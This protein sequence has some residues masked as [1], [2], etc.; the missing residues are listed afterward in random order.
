MCVGKCSRYVGL[1]LVLLSLLSI[2]LQLFLLYP[3]FD[4]SYLDE[5]NISSH[6]RK[7]AGIWA[8]GLLVGRH[9]CKSK[10]SI[11]FDLLF[12]ILLYTSD[13]YVFG[14]PVWSDICDKP[15]MIV[16][17]TFSFFFLLGLVG[18]LQV[19]L[20]FFQI[21]NSFIGI[22]GGRCDGYKWRADDGP[23]DK[24]KAPETGGKEDSL[25][26]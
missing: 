7:Y 2:A 20:S 11:S 18:V 9:F 17:W 12:S 10:L 13:V 1:S 15:P 16:P 3:N 6:V 5:G 26:K 14:I 25:P 21:I 4:G 23:G 8:G 24:R 19:V 22:F